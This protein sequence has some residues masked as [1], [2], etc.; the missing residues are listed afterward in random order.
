MWHGQAHDRDPVILSDGSS[1]PVEGEFVGE[2]AAE[3]KN[4]FVVDASPAGR[5]E[6]SFA[7]R[8]R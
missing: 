4:L 2:M 1:P 6:R 3:S 7:L 8:S 5:T